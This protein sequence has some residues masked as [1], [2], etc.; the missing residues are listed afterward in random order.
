MP[1]Y[2]FGGESVKRVEKVDFSVNLQNYLKRDGSNAATGPLNMGTNKISEVVDPDDDQDAAT[3][4]Y[5]DDKTLTESKGKDYILVSGENNK[6]VETIA[7]LDDIPKSVQRMLTPKA[8]KITNS[9][10]PGHF[11]LTGADGELVESAV[12]QEKYHQVHTL[13]ANR[14]RDLEAA[15]PILSDLGYIP[16][17]LAV[18]SP[19]HVWLF[20]SQKIEA[21]F[22]IKLTSFGMTAER[23]GSDL[24]TLFV[25]IKI[26][27]RISTTTYNL[28]SSLSSLLLDVPAGGVFTIRITSPSAIGFTKGTYRL[29]YKYI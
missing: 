23:S 10:G 13:L 12:L 22:P 5:V 9:K 18:Q 24:L 2:K 29:Y 3:K 7:K 15:T 19:S 28:S 25:D 21:F 6:I 20:K 8:D 14:I 11:V 4:K 26:Q 17:D 27:N 16:N 1:V